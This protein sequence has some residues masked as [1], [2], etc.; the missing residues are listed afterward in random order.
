MTSPAFIETI[1]Q[2]ALA[3][4]IQFSPTAFPWLESTHVLFLV[5]VVGSILIVDLRLIGVAAHRP[6]TRQLIRELLPYTWVAFVGAVITGSLLFIS[7]AAQYWESTVLLVKLG[8]I[9]LAGLNMA[10]FHLT[11]YRNIDEWDASPTPPTPARVAGFTSLALWL[12]VVFLGRWIGFSAP[13]L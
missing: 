2:S 9:V 6:G 12:L 4:W 13:F 10:V 3:E 5:C 1:G 11:A 7:N 8:A